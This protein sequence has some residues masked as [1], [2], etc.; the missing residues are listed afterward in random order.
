MFDWQ[1]LRYFLALARAGSL[2]RAADEL[3]VEHATVGRR[4]ASLEAVLGLKLVHRLPRNTR[5]TED[6]L[7]VAELAAT[8]SESAQAIESF[9]LRATSALSGV[10]R[11]S[12]PP[13]VGNFCVAQYMQTFHEAHPSLTI[14]M[15]NTP[16]IA[17]LNR[18]IAD[19]AIRMVKPEEADLLT[20]RIG[21][22]RFGLY[23]SPAYASRPVA[24]WAF[25]AYDASLNHVKHQIWLRRFLDGRPIVF[26]ASDVIAQQMAARNGVGVAVLPTLLGER[27]AELVR[28]DAQAG[29][30]ESGLW[31]VTY[32]DLRRAPAIK[33]VMAFL[34]DCIAREPLLKSA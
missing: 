33:A 13:T 11:I 29:P 16:D 8:M 30:P 4:I 7:V 19:V 21:T 14:V 5:L 18:G 34:V 28:L 32:P 22:M 10:V 12:V 25:I 2:S 1:D 27:D 17:P 9:A 6:G 3:S 31:L 26:E 15:M 23:A 20:R 24:Q